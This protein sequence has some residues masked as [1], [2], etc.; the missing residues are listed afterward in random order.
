ML[1]TS[2]LTATVR[3]VELDRLRGLAILLMIGDHL[4]RIWS[5]EGYRLTLGRLAMPLFFIIC[6]H[7]AG[8]RLSRRHLLAFG[9]GL[10]LPVLVPWVDSPNVLVWLSIGAVILYVFDQHGWPTWVLI[11]PALILAANSW[12]LWTNTHS[13]DPLALL[14]LM[15]L[16]RGL[17]P[18]VFIFGRGIPAWVGALGRRPLT[19]YV[20]SSLAI[21]LVL[22]A[23]GRG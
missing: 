14:A 22:V 18:A 7:L 15:A 20:G 16:G 17:A 12:A 23:V 10:G 19:W 6:G 9:L 4:A 2:T 11:V 13:Y 5:Y 8:H 1:S 21:Q 3:R